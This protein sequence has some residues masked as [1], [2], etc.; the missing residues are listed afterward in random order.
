M[1][2]LSIRTTVRSLS[3]KL[4]AGCGAANGRASQPQHD[5]GPDRKEWQVTM[6]GYVELN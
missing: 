3:H 5:A 6:C 4:I 1:T 2:A